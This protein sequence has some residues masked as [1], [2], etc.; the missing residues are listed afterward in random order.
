[1][2]IAEVNGQRI[3]WEEAGEGEPLMLVMGLTADHLAWALQVRE[4]QKDFRVITFDNRDAGQ[5]SECKGEYEV[6]DMAADAIRLADE[7][8]LDSFHLVGASLGGA[9]AQ[10]MALSSPERIRTLTLAITWAGAGNWGRKFHRLWSAQ[11]ERTPW[12]EHIDNLMLLVF[13]EEFFDDQ[14]RVTFMRQTMLGNP[15]P[16]SKESFTRQV[17]AAGRHETRERLPHLKMPVH[18]IGAEHD[19][20]VP[21]WKSEEIA[22]LIPGAKLTVIEGA[23]HSVNIERADEFNAAVRDFILAAER[24]AA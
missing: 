8:G 11:V 24:K 2:P 12:E 20:L 3:Y 6:T 9:I 7:L 19:R 16:Q 5:S 23:A 17:G 10:E 14:E 18:V 4:L 1:M 15:F 13:S 22:A 21:V